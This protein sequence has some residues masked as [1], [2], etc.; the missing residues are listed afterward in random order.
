MSQRGREPSA[1]TGL[2]LAEDSG[3]EG[4]HQGAQ[5]VPF[6]YSRCVMCV[7]S[8]AS[9]PGSSPAFCHILFFVQY[10][11]KSWGGAWE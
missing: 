3:G 6:S 11:T 2:S 5:E 4:T 10:A 9:F 7:Y 8:V 1:A